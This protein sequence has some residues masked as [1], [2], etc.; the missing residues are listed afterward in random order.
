M[1]TIG[2]KVEARRFIPKTVRTEDFEFG[3]EIV[4]E[5]ISKGVLLMECRRAY[6]RCVRVL[7]DKQGSQVGWVFEGLE[8]DKHGNII[9]PR[10]WWETRVYITSGFVIVGNMK[11]V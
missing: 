4:V 7:R 11:F 3:D 5:T 2:L 10:S 9:Q 8:K 1:H 6:G